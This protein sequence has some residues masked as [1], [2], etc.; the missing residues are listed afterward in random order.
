M[1]GENLTRC[2]FSV[3]NNNKFIIYQN[4]SELSF[5]GSEISS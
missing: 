1:I 3:N 5:L 2:W 4:E